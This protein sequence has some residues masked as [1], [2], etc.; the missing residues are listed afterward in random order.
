MLDMMQCA[1]LAL[2]AAYELTLQACVEQAGS[3]VFA[4]QE[5]EW[6]DQLGGGSS[7]AS[8]SPGPAP[9][10]SCPGKH[11]HYGSR[12]LILEHPVTFFPGLAVTS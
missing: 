6:P 1:G 9:S 8:A 5:A 12:P 4:D 11:A 7:A 3:Q 10:S 2:S